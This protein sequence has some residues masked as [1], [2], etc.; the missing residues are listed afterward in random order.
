[1]CKKTAR[2]LPVLILLCALGCKSTMMK[3]TPL[4][5]GEYSKPQGP[6]EDRVNMWPL[7]YYHDPALSLLW[8]VGE[9]TDDHIS[10]RPIFSVY[11]LDK[12]E[13]EWSFLWPLSNLDFDTKHYR[14]FPVFW[15]GRKDEDSD[16]RYFVAF[17]LAWK[18]PDWKGVFP[19][20]CWHGETTDGF[21]V[22]PLC[23]YEKDE[24]FHFF[25]LWLYTRPSDDY[26]D[27]SVLWPIFRVKKTKD[28]KGF[29][30]WPLIGAYT[31]G[32]DSHERY[33]LWPLC[34]DLRD[35]DTRTRVA[36]PLYFEHSEGE[37]GWWAAVPVAFHKQEGGDATTITPIWASGK[38]G[39]ARWSLLLPLY[40]RSSNPE[41][42]TERLI[43]PLGG[44]SKS[45]EK[46]DLT[47]IPLLSSYTTRDDEKEIWALGPMARAR[48]GG[49]KLQHHVFP[50]YYYDSEKNM[51]LSPIASRRAGDDGSGFFNLLGLLAH[52]SV[53]ARGKK[54]FGAL[55]P[56][57]EFSWDDDGEHRG[58]KVFPLFSWERT[59]RPDMRRSSSWLLPWMRFKSYEHG[60]VGEET[61]SS[62][63]NSFFPFWRYS[64]DYN[65]RPGESATPPGG[66]KAVKQAPTDASEFSILG[67]LYD[68]KHR[69]VISEDPKKAED[70]TRKR[71]LWRVMHYERDGGDASLDLFP[72]ITWDK[73]ADGYRK[74]SFMWRFFRNE[75][76]PDGS[77][78]IDLLFIPVMRKR[79]AE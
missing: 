2:Y 50:L 11:K 54:M 52:Y 27:A 42:K 17:P 59:R 63:Y 64:Y 34:H 70:Y 69:K 31:D 55:L 28:E 22:L 38:K 66:P 47:I 48:W 1:M 57:T 61:A 49:D 18:M 3:G 16:S 51:F 68:S 71:M 7:L 24:Y 4:Y 56:L 39:D 15:G 10:V 41:Q 5:S 62:R 14:V 76:K 19:V 72:F 60:T 75:R 23:W 12:D 25:P 9:A 44:W 43:T 65:S 6:P 21:T 40:F 74:T 78:N 79:A 26:L 46:S 33:A 73:K 53:D 30:I 8:P 67:W 58:A 77:R 13:Q 32:E 29:R 20:F 36:F 35:G 37:D 45:P